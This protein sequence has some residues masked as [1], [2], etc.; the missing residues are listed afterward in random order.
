MTKRV[1]AQAEG[2]AAGP[3]RFEVMGDVPLG[4]AVDVEWEVALDGLAGPTGDRLDGPGC[5]VSGWGT[6]GILSGVYGRCDDLPAGAVSFELVL[7]G[8]VTSYDLLVWG[9]VPLTLQA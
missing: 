1:L 6:G 8:A 4:G 2:T 3:G 5:T 9:W 7:E